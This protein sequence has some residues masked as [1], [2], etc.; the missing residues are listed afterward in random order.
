MQNVISNVHLSI[1]SF[2]C[3]CQIEIDHISLILI[4]C[5]HVPKSNKYL[6]LPCE[7]YATYYIGKV[8]VV[9]VLA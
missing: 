6:I 8:T 1:C 9:S 5:I 4:E 2:E 7:Y 3:L